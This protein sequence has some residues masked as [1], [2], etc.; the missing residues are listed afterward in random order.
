MK[1][2]LLF[3]LW[4]SFTHSIHA[5]VT[6]I[7]NNNSLSPV[8]LLNNNLAIAISGIDQT[9][10]ATDAT[11]AG[12]IQLS[13]T[14]H[15]IGP[16]VVLNEKYIFVGSTA[17][18]GS[19]I[20]ITD[21][22]VSGTKIISDIVTGT[23]G[24]TDPSD[25][26]T[27]LN[28]YVYFIASTAATGRE[29][30]RTDGTP[31]NTAIVADIIAGPTGSN[32]VGEYNLTSAGSYL[33]LDVRTTAEGNELWRSDGTGANTFLLKDI[34]VGMPSSNPGFFFPFN[35]YMLFSI[36]AADGIHQEIWRTDG[37]GAGTILL[38]N[39]ITPGLFTVGS[40]FHVFNNRAYFA[41]NDGTYESAIWSTDAVDATV[42]HTAFLQDEGITGP[43]AS[44][45]AAGLLD[46][47]NLAGKFIFPVTDGFTRFELWESDG[48]TAAGTKLF[49]S[50]PP[51]INSAVPV[52]FVNIGF[53][54]ATQTA[55]Y[56]LFNGNFF[57][58][59]NSTTEGNELWK[60]DGTV[61]GT[62]MVKDI[63]T[64]LPDGITENLS[65]FYSSAGLYFAATN[66]TQGNELWKSDGTDAGTTIVKDINVLA[67][68][69]GSSDPG[70][71]LIV[72]GKIMFTATDGDNAD[73]TDL[74]VVDGIFTPL[75]VKLLDFTVTPKNADA[76]LNWRTSQEIN[77]KNYTIQRSF[78]GRIY[79][80]VGTVPASGTSATGKAYSFIDAGIINSGKSIVYY[81]LISADVDGKT[82]TSPVITL[83][84][85]GTGKWNVKLLSN[86]VS[87]NLKIVL[88]GITENVQLSIVDLH[89][90]K[91]YTHQLSAVNGQ[92]SIPASSLASGIYTL[93]TETLNE[94]KTI[95]FVK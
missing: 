11:A 31:G 44:Y 90:R 34:V 18:E 52:I 29:L 13:S 20:F 36:T 32:I 80:S 61:A 73:E 10:W 30:W 60:S 7:N 14:I 45:A 89:G 62:S 54:T 72:N 4:S 75:P 91:L 2:I 84:L 19:E 74:F 40:F 15:A 70:L 87:E 1:K 3:A 28:G 59:A 58:T 39:N 25:E 8:T 5:Q 76:V 27:L 95:Q 41:I 35:N 50:F 46:A 43:F 67:V 17:T 51:N 49:K 77:S 37:T 71:G 38:K 56:P 81:R 69:T 23:T 22:T 55:T 79:E 16:G 64:G 86:P 94:R 26:I 24:S 12:T 93:I 68:N 53:N 47:F 85:N 66:G 21:G 42:A 83:K 92:I 48:A 78:D 6:R 33:L 82:F 65:Y 9:L 63:N 57:F 88:A